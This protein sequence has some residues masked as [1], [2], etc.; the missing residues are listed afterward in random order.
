M[1]FGLSENAH[2]FFFRSLSMMLNIGCENEWRNKCR[3][4]WNVMNE[5]ENKHSD[6]LH[7]HLS[8]AH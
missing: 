6:T 1:S 7:R 3:K 8:D 4:T 2:C 5:K